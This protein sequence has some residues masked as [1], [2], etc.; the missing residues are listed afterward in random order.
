MLLFLSSI[1][2]VFPNIYVVG[3]V[4]DSWTSKKVMPTARDALGVAVV[5]EKLYALGG[6]KSGGVP[7][8]S[9]EEYDPDTDTWT[10]K[11]SMPTLVD[12]FGV[13]VYDN[14]I[15]V[16]GGDFGPAG[17]HQNY[18][19]LVYNSATDTWENRAEM[20]T[21]RGRLDA[22]L[23]DGKIYVI[24]GSTTNRADISSV[25]EVYDTETDTW[26]TRAQIPTAVC[27]YA[28]AVVDSKIYVIGGFV[29]STPPDVVATNLTQIYDT[30][31]DTWSHGAPIPT[32]I[33]LAAATATTGEFAPKRIHVLCKDSHYVYDPE[34]DTWTTATAMPT[35]RSS[36]GIATVNDTI[37][38]IGGTLG[39][40]SKAATNEQ[41][42]PT[43]YIPE[44]PRFTHIIFMLAIVAVV[45]GVYKRW[46]STRQLKCGSE[47]A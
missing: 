28:S 21:P 10:T 3:A 26:T 29:Q 20:L 33:S 41:Y 45:V 36:L 27:S 47:V 35:P 19:N 17:P 18:T 25:N 14:L 32:N 5:N 8:D 1:A 2:F 46:L 37:Y 40:N 44:F 22:N 12:A 23:V 6:L 31:T 13:T 7:V 34:T 24:G 38:T 16:I 9:N 43:G 11:T 4:E 15:Y 42:T 30:E 39:N